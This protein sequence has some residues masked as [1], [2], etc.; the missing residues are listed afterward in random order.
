LIILAHETTGFDLVGHEEMGNELRLFVPEFLEFRKKCKA[1]RLDIP[2]LFHCGETLDVGDKVDGNLFDA[3][4]RHPL[5]MDI[6]KEKKI[7]I[8]T[9]PISNEVL[10]LTSVIAGHHLPILLANDV[11]C[12]INS[13]NATFYKWVFSSSSQY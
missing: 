10:G 13:D 1:Q 6:F 4:A 3:I 12:T 7:A 9:C 8:E 2:F 11:P 5:L